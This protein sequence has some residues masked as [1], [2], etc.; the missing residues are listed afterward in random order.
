[1]KKYVLLFFAAFIMSACASVPTELTQTMREACQL[2]QE[3]RPVVIDYREYAIANWDKI[4]PDMQQALVKLDGYLPELEKAGKTICLAS[5]GLMAAK[6]SRQVDWDQVLST[7]IS[8]A[9][10]AIELH[11]AGVF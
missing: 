10:K 11:Q 1:M 4:P 2:Y 9:A 3:T 6:S 7:T 5:D 8:V